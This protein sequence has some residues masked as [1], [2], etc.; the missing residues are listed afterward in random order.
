MVSLTRAIGEFIA[1]LRFTD[2]PGEA[3]R[4][5]CNGFTDVA[6]CIILGR[7]MPVVD[8]VKQ[9]SSVVPS[10]GEARVC[11]SAQGAHA[12]DAALINGTAAHAYDYDDIGIGAHP[13][14][15]SAVLVPAIL[16]EAEALRRGGPETIAAYVA[17]YEVWGELARRDA[18]PHHVKGWHP[19]G[20]FGS[21]AAAA[22]C[23][24]LRRLDAGRAAHAVG[25][26]A[27]Q[28]AG[29]VANFGSMAKP[30]HAGRAAQVGVLSARLAAAGMTAASDVIE[31]PKGFLHAVSPRGAID[32]ETPLILGREWWLLRHGLGFKLYP[33]CYGAHRSLDGMLE[34]VGEHDVV[35]D[36]VT[37]VEV[38]M[39]PNQQLNLVNHDPQTAMD[40]KFSEEFAMAMA[41]IARRA[42]MAEVADGFVRRDDV[43]AL[44]KKVRITTIPGVGD[45]RPTTPPAD[46]ITVTL[47]DGRRLQ[48]KLDNP[49]GHPERPL[50][51]EELWIKFADCVSDAMPTVSARLFFDQ[52]QALDKLGSVTELP[53]VEYGRPKATLGAPLPAGKVRIG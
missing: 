30:F 46:R 32:V 53:L 19:T 43:R 12:T 6:A 23:A 49:R 17:G 18:D 50:G 47:R 34:L 10:G 20:V 22:A 33:M 44:M 52:L 39:S 1:T 25:I 51:G 14:H 3:M 4:I 29:L 48:R 7:D 2:V 28:A 11:F 40:A 21:L 24:K 16:A 31:Q 13:A 27:S 45:D 35:A 38:E 8:A 9:V 15:P 37:D 5:V 41:I 42:T 26:A 36:D